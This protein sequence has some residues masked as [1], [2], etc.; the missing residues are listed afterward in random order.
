MFAVPGWGLVPATLKKQ[1]DQPIVPTN[2]I[3]KHA[4]EGRSRKRKRAG[5]TG[6]QELIKDEDI[7]A[8]WEQ[9]VEGKP[10]ASSVKESVDAKTVKSNKPKQQTEAKEVGVSSPGQDTNTAVLGKG[11]STSK[12]LKANVV[13]EESSKT[14]R[15]KKQREEAAKRHDGGAATTIEAQP[16]TAEPRK[17]AA[18]VPVH[19]VINPAAELKLTPLQAAMRQK[20]N[21][22]R[23]RHLNQ[24][25]YTAPSTESMDL[26]KAN[27]TFFE[28]YHSGFR[29][30]VSAWPENPV[31]G[32]VQDLKE[33]GKVRVLRQIDKFRASQGQSGED[34]KDD[35]NALPRNHGT[36][37]VA[38]LG[39]GDAMLGREM[40]KG[41]GAKLKIKVLSYD[42]YSQNPHVI[43]A[44]IAR[45]PLKDG[46]ANI[47]IFCLALMG[48]NWLDF[49]EEAWRILHWKGEL[50]IAEIKSRFNR[51]KQD[52]V[53]DHSVGKKRK[54]QQK[55]G[56]KVDD[57]REQAELQEQL[58]VEV[59]G[60]EGK[61]QTDISSF[62]EVLRRRG[63]ALQSETAI[64]MS[65][66]MFVK[67][68][69]T[70]S[71]SPVKGKNQPQATKETTATGEK[72][73]KFLEDER[74]KE[75]FD[76]KSVLKPCLY[77][78]R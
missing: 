54:I 41:I 19:P 65:N 70:K 8:M 63:F 52:R 67:M 58:A 57:R 17:I 18:V 66:K 7:A 34:K 20:L 47:A 59:D 1:V 35:G 24:T 78:L 2:Q 29:Q 53:V 28:E 64:D 73:T 21:S 31:N 3:L 13:K 11:R 50:W 9:H 40:G 42:L 76:E 72:M 68:K 32:F 75:S 43:Q 10:P 74:Q 55:A 69:F 25:L 71:L 26:F 30:Q 49:I 39:C 4:E 37:V 45:V 44:D 12:A 27:P 6:G 51:G 16:D 22:A 36:C 33:R 14:K 38:D 15:R 5:A 23:F 56:S 77:K 60:S 61:S 46:E 62:V 48:T